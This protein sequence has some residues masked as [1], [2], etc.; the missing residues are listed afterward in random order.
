MHRTATIPALTPP[1]PKRSY[2]CAL[3]RSKFACRSWRCPR[4]R[5]R[6]LA[7]SF[8]R[9]RDALTRRVG[10]F[11]YLVLEVPLR[12]RDPWHAASRAVDC[13]L[14]RAARRFGKLGYYLCWEQN[15]QG[16][17]HANVILHSRALPE[18][19]LTAFLRENARACGLSPAVYCEPVQ[20]KGALA[21]Y[22]SKSK[23]LPLAAP[24]SEGSGRPWRRTRASRGFLPR[25]LTSRPKKRRAVPQPEVGVRN[26][27]D[28]RCSRP[29]AQA[30]QDVRGAG[31]YGPAGRTLVQPLLEGRGVRPH[32]GRRHY[33]LR[34]RRPAPAAPNGPHHVAVAD[35]SPLP[36]HEPA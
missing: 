27:Q 15:D 36:P 24:V 25:A 34:D 9:L 17:P 14:R 16:H 5:R 22:L 2:Y 13:L 28:S 23:Q 35:V 33:V 20:D 26:A 4:C 19:E 12:T 30:A 29:A 7:Q 32:A 18:P 6:H 10:R 11:Y 1:L 31:M 8:A 3:G 21:G